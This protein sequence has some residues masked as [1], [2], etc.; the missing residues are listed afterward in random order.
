MTSRIQ[1]FGSARVPRCDASLPSGKQRNDTKTQAFHHLV[2]RTDVRFRYDS[3]LI[4]NADRAMSSGSKD[5]DRLRWEMLA[6]WIFVVFSFAALV[7]A[8]Y[9]IWA[10]CDGPS[11][12]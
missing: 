2:N 5:S 8:V 4:S 1:I 10:K 11:P 9:A 3:C 12:F 7:F 6:L